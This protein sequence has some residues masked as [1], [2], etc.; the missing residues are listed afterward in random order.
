MTDGP[1]YISL[2]KQPDVETRPRRLWL[3][4]HGVTDWNSEKRLC[5]QSD[6]LLSS[7]GEKQAHAVGQWL[8]QHTIAAIYSSDLQRAVQ[9]TAIIGAY[10]PSSTPIQASEAWRELSFGAWE[11]LTYAEVAARYPDQLGFF[12][13]PTQ[14]TPPDGESFMALI[15]RVRAGFIQLAQDAVTLPEGDIVLVGHGGA[16]RVLIC[17]ILGMPFE[18]Q[19]QVRLDHGSLSALDFLA[20]TDDVFSTTSLS[21]LNQPAGASSVGIGDV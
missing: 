9:T 8:C 4:R 13:H 1:E 15:A 14:Q 5:G 12:T 3:I 19:W 7:T 2:A 11:G 10:L 6:P 18:R 21:L 16:L 20:G 17:L